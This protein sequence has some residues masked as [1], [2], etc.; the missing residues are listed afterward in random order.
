MVRSHPGGQPNTAGLRLAVWKCGR[1][2]AAGQLMDMSV[3]IG[4]VSL[5][6]GNLLPTAD[7]SKAGR[8]SKPSVF[9]SGPLES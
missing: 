1:L 4:R 6:F 3:A 9:S 8:E 7:P 5:G 2:W